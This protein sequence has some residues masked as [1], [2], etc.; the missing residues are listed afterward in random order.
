MAYGKS[1]Q[2]VF[3]KGREPKA[4]AVYE[5]NGPR[6][7]ERRRRQHEAGKLMFVKVPPPREFQHSFAFESEARTHNY[8]NWRKLREA[9]RALGMGRREYDVHKAAEERNQQAAA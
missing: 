3:R 4:Y 5:R 1:T 2:L 6:E 8:G 7:C 9:R